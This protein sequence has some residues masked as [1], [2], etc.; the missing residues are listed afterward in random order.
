M[1]IYCD[2]NAEKQPKVLS[3]LG[4]FGCTTK[5]VVDLISFRQIH[6][7]FDHQQYSL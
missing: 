1:D 3:H 7:I 5:K 4:I 2:N 6:Y